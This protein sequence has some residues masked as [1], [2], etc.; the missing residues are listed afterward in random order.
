MGV[1]STGMPEVNTPEGNDADAPS[2]AYDE[3]RTRYQVL[4]KVVDKRKLNT[5]WSLSAN[6]CGSSS[7]LSSSSLL[8]CAQLAWSDLVCL[9]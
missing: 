2:G 3:H 4:N 5:N 8:P 1:D 9:C 6:W 7:L